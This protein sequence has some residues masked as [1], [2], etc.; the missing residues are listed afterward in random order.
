MRWLYLTLLLTAILVVD[1][2]AQTRPILF[3]APQQVAWGKGHFKLKTS[4]PIYS[5]SRR[6]VFDFLHRL[7]RLTGSHHPLK[8]SARIRFMLLKSSD[9]Q[10][11]SE[12]YRLVVNPTSITVRANTARGLFYGS[13]TLLELVDKRG[14]RFQVP[15]VTIV[16]WPAMAYRGVMLDISRGLVPNTSTFERFI[17]SLARM[18]FNDL[19]PYIEDTYAFKQYPF[20]GRDRGAWTPAEVRQFAKVARN[21]FIDLSPCFESLGHMY[22]ILK[23]PEMVA[24]RETNDVISP[25][26]PATYTFLNNCYRELTAAFPGRYLN[27]GC[28]ETFGLG[29]GPS[30][31]LV[32]KEGVGKVYADHMFRLDKLCRRY[33]RE[34]Q[35]WGDM[36]L[37]YPGI[38]GEMPKDAIVMNWD[39]WD[40][41]Q[42]PAIATYKS[43]GYQQIVCPSI[44]AH[45]SIFPNLKQANPNIQGFIR[46]GKAAGALGVL[47]TCWRDNGE[48]FFDYDWY[49]DAICAGSAWSTQPIKGKTFDRGFDRNFFGPGG[50]DLAKAF[51]LLEDN[52]N[53]FAGG[54][55]DQGFQFYYNDP[56]S[57]LWV[58]FSKTGVL[59]LD[60]LLEISERVTDLVNQAQPAYHAE[61]IPYLR[62][63]AERLAFIARK[64]EMAA[65]TARLYN[66]A[67]LPHTTS[68]EQQSLVNQAIHQLKQLE[69]AADNLRNQYATLW[70]RENHMPGLQVVLNRYD[71]MV[72]AFQALEGRLNAALSGLKAGKPL[73]SAAS[74][75]LALPST[76]ESGYRIPFPLSSAPQWAKGRLALHIQLPATATL[77]SPLPAR[78]VVPASSI[79]AGMPHIATLNLV[80]S[81]GKITDTIGCQ[82]DRTGKKNV[83]LTFILPSGTNGT[84][85]CVLS[86]RPAKVFNGVEIKPSHRLKGGWWVANSRF[87]AL[88]GRE[89]A[90]LYR[91]DVAKLGGQDI[92]MP[93][94]TQWHGFDDVGAERESQFTLKP[95]MSGPICAQILASAPDG[96]QKTLTFYAGLGWYET[97]F[98]QP[99]GFF[100]HYDDP[101]VMG[102]SSVTPGRYRYANGQTGFLP[103]E[104]SM[105]IGVVSRW[106]AKYR[107]DGLTL[108]LISPKG[109]AMLRAGPGD[110]MGGV[111]VEGGGVTPYVVT[112]ADVNSGKWRAVADIYAS[113]ESWIKA[114]IGYW[115]AGSP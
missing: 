48:V 115:P 110:G 42:F 98:S 19:Q 14:N 33:H 9:S 68:Q 18:K 60:R 72:N 21:Y 111:G 49:P 34:M 73:P 79:G 91:W 97:R 27:V 107:P 80:D 65:D 106:V 22:Q 81:A 41:T 104:G 84:L 56:F 83:Y 43:Y 109:N 94:D 58:A 93:G 37:R 31:A 46:A 52:V 28:D 105:S 89:G 61:V 11:G 76:N 64:Y 62:Y 66:Q 8:Q 87:H 30:K 114:K 1:A 67:L 59:A 57:N 54:S 96:F 10:I 113:V 4:E 101:N 29:Q 99:V 36:M 103:T 102:S 53:V 69:I 95:V 85:L 7:H 51:T 2:S 88:L 92:T 13:E 40:T 50:D 112:Y 6:A 32:A 44:Q 5:D 74:I 3:P 25:A 15:A 17:R 23:H 12:G 71:P 77:E 16:D 86:D 24:L 100:W 90:H 82:V 47:N 70:L 63:G 78:I 20:I 108:G 45:G 75:G 55:P 38:V 26:V 35:F 39:Y